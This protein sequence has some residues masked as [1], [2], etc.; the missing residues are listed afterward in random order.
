MAEVT[1]IWTLTRHEFCLF[2]VHTSLGKHSKLEKLAN[3]MHLGFFSL[4]TRFMNF[5]DN[6]ASTCDPGIFFFLDRNKDHKLTR[7]AL[8]ND[9]ILCNK[10][11]FLASVPTGRSKSHLMSQKHGIGR[12]LLVFSDDAFIR[13]FQV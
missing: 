3:D 8:I 2:A 5:K 13:Y 7:G 1:T 12:M 11:I 4:I 9:L 10:N 6:K